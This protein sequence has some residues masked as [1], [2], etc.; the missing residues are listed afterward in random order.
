[1]TRHTLSTEPHG[2]S[3]TVG[4]LTAQLTTALYERGQTMFILAGVKSITGLPPASACSLVRRGTVS[5]LEPGLFVLVPPELGRL[6]DYALRLRVGAVVRCLGYL[7]SRK[8][9][10]AH[11]TLYKGIPAL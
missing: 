1:M 7:L 11:T 10:F 2:P 3:K 5:R 9:G 4:A 6:V 8:I